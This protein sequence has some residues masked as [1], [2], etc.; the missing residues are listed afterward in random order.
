MAPSSTAPAGVDAPEAILRANDVAYLALCDDLLGV[1]GR[2]AGTTLCCLQQ[3]AEF[4]QFFHPGRFADGGLENV[5]LVGG[6]RLERLAGG[7]GPC[8]G[9]GGLGGGGGPRR[10]VLHVATAV[11]AVGGH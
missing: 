4:C 8:P 5:A 3:I 11:Q 10:H 1:G 9:L 7:W 6:K 2:G